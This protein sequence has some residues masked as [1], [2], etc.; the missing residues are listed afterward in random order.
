MMADFDIHLDEENEFRFSVTTEGTDATAEVYSRLVIDEGRMSISFPGSNTADGEVSVTVPPLIKILSEGVYS[1]RLEVI[2]DDRIFIPIE[3][4]ASFKQSM[5]VMA[6]AIV[7]PRRIAP[8][9]TVTSV[10]RSTA[11]SLAANIRKMQEQ[12]EAPP[13]RR[14]QKPKKKTKVTADNAELREL[15]RKV[16]K[17]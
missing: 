8:S 3:M 5:K 11:S 17:K 6:E 15:L 1:T 4:D 2:V 10:K 12:T 16:I 14:S 13:K 7:K 9:V